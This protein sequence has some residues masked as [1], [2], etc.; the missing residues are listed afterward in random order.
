M[1]LLFSLAANAKAETTICLNDMNSAAA[2]R[3]IDP[4]LVKIGAEKFL[5]LTP[6]KYREMTGQRLGIKNAVA[7]KAAQI[8]VKNE[9]GDLQNSEP[10]IDKNVYILLAIF[11][12]AWIAM[13]LFSDWDGSDWIVNLL[14]TML[15]WL[16]GLIHALTKMKEYYK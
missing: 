5:D 10:D 16:P 8:K 1:V 12:L 3:E 13:G 11:G 7:L 9:L 4:N 2:V 15:C 6:A 14:L